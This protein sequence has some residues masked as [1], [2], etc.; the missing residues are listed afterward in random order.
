M[1]LARALNLLRV[2]SSEGRPLADFI[3][4]ELL[5]LDK[6]N[7]RETDEKILYQRQGACQLLEDLERMIAESREK[8][9]DFDTMRRQAEPTMGVG[10]I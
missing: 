6:L 1:R 5:R 4:S 10:Q 8:Y 7:R 3:S 2:E 9:A